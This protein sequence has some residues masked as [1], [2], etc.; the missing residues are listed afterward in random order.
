M[1][2]PT[3]KDTIYI[4]AEDEITTIIDKV[5][6]S[7]TKVVALVLPKRSSTLQSIVNLKLL[8]RTGEQAKKN[9]VLITSDK[10]LLPMAGSVGLH[11]AKTLQTKPVV[12][13]APKL[14]TTAITV[15]DEAAANIEPEVEADPAIDPTT[16]IGQLAGQLATEETIELDNVSPAETKLAGVDTKKAKKLKIPDFDRF[17]L[18]VFGGIG[19]LILLIVGGIFALVILPKAKVVIKT[20]TTSI[21]TN[22]LV[23]A[24][25]DTKAVSIKDLAVPATSKQLKKTGS[26]KVPATGQRNDGTKASG[27][28]TIT[29]CSADVANLPAGTTF[30]SGSF[31]FLSNEAV[32]VPKSSYSITPGGFVC[33][34]NGSKSVG[35]TAQNGG[36]TYNLGARPYQ[37][38]GSPT[39]LS[40]KGS[41][42]KG[43]TSKLVQVVS[44]A[45]I[46]N[47]RQK[48]IDKLTSAAAGELKAQFAS[49]KAFVLADTITA[50]EPVV[51]SNPNLN[52]PSTEV[53]V[54][55]TV[56][57]GVLGVKQDDL[58]QLVVADVN[59]HID[60]S[61]QVIQDDGLGQAVIGA[62]EKK[63]DTAARF[64]FKSLTVAGPQLDSDGIKK[65]IAGKKKG[66][67]L[68]VIQSRPGIKDVKITYSPFWVYSTPKQTSHITVIFEQNNAKP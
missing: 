31:N 27:T 22:L 67:A 26:E 33:D 55:V 52:E 47:A 2:E 24:S 1:S 14:N 11:V 20:D 16:P 39:N 5:R 12:P 36:D 7:N 66:D 8:K 43:G 6:S 17:R 19:L 68:R 4:D 63:S 57:F 10:N 60:P 65:Q 56:T 18:L 42:M 40:A 46:N 61:K 29:N 64:E 34:G 38:A 58:K 49:E 44:Q 54:S 21:N 51:V 53:N 25:T 32:A 41:D 48:V 23:T 45:D 37:I 59:K 28:M 13:S 3:T 15:D 35:V 9:L 62:V 30:S 50:G